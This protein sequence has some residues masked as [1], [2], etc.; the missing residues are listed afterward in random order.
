MF[1]KVNMFIYIISFVILLLN[2]CN[3]HLIDMNIIEEFNKFLI[4]YNKN[5]DIKE[6]DKR[7]KIF[8]EN[9]DTI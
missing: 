7:L 1:N 8:K 6:Y 2:I 3:S 4:T 9:Y 5:Y